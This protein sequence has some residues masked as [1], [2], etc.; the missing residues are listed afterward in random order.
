[1]S[2]GVRITCKSF[3]NDRLI[4]MKLRRTFDR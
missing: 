4:F 2:L 3:F 1:M